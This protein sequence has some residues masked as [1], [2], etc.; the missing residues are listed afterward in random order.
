MSGAHRGRSRSRRPTPRPKHAAAFREHRHVLTQLPPPRPDRQDEFGATACPP[1]EPVRRRTDEANNIID[2]E[3][4]ETT[5]EGHIRIAKQVAVAAGWSV[6]DAKVQLGTAIEPLGFLVEA[7]G[8]GRIACTELKREGIGIELAEQANAGP[9]GVKS[10]VVER[11]A[12]RLVNLAT[13]IV[14]G[15]AHLE[16]LYRVRRVTYTVKTSAGG[17]VKVRPSKL[18]VGGSSGGARDYQAAIAWWRAALES[19][20]S[21]PLAPRLVFPAVSDVGTVVTFQDAARGAGTGYGGFAPLV[22]RHSGTRRMLAM[23]QVWPEDLRLL[24]FNNE[25]SMPAGE[26]FALAALAIAVTLKVGGV[27]HIIA[28]TDS[29]PAASAINYS[30][31]GSPQLQLILQ[32]LYQ[33]CPRL[34]LLAIWLPGK[35]NTRSDALSRGSVKALEAFDEATAAGWDPLVVDPPPYACDLLRSVATVGY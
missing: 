7:H 1:G 2:A 35:D 24:L 34:Q 9:E 14:E 10:E 27:S 17:S 33:A 3:A 30:A 21:V 22:N 4:E 26:L 11:L 15:R 23:T 31:S 6:K 13:V 18:S 19:D 20:M 12:G 29:A 28:F 8:E 32:W 5:A 25:I 16:P